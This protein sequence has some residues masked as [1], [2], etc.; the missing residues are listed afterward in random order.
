MILDAYRD[1][2]GALKQAEVM[3]L[4]VLKKAGEKLD[5]VKAELKAAPTRS[6]VPGHRAG[7]AGE[8]GA[9]P[10]RAAASHPGRGQA[11][12]DRQGPLGQPDGLLQHLRGHHGPH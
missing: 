12:P 10:R 1:I 11:L 6:R 3:A 8:A 2:R 5:A 4:E 9:D 7:R